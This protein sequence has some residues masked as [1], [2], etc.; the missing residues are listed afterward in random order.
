[1][2][3][4]FLL[5]IVILFNFITTSY[6]AK[7]ISVDANSSILIDYHTNDVLYE[8]NSDHKIYPASMTKIMTAIIA[9]DLLQKGD[10]TLDEEFPSAHGVALLAH[11][12]TARFPAAHS[13]HLLLAIFRVIEAEPRDRRH[14]VS[15]VLFFLHFPLKL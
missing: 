5:L 2:K 14:R 13:A 12:P 1:M 15:L 3:K 10:V 11:L 6:A 9:F 7:K 4:I 8:D